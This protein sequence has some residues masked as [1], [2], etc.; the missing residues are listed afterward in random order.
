MIIVK[1][2]TN[3]KLAATLISRD[4]EIA[5][6]ERL[7]TTPLTASDFILGYALPFLPLAAAQCVICCLA[8]FLLG[9]KFTVS[10]IF[11]V[12]FILPVS[13]FF[14]SLGLLCGGALNVKQVGE[15]CGAAIQMTGAESFTVTDNVILDVAANALHIYNG[16]P[17]KSITI[18]NNIISAAYL[19]RNEADYDMNKVI[20]AGNTISIINEG[21]CVNKTEVI[22][23]SFTLE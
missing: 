2:Y 18:K 17:A 15:I 10:V 22:D 9:L 12:L 7:Y 6:L 4:R 3:L 11:S 16:C 1:I 23:S 13:V 21:K 19:C 5:L 14:I 8:A 20:C